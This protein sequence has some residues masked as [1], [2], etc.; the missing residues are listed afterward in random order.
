M[1]KKKGLKAIP[2][3][4]QL[5]GGIQLKA[6]PFTIVEYHDDGRPKLFEIKDDGPHP[7]GV[8]G[9]CVLFAQE[10][11]IRSRHPGKGKE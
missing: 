4:L 3:V 9:N 11:W 8:D 7:L 1:E 6:M 2:S 5:P 10:A